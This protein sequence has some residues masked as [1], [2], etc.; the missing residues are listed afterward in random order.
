M[1]E[2]PTTVATSD[3]A[4][5]FPPPVM[6]GES[7]KRRI[8]RR[9]RPGEFR[10][11][12]R[13]RCGCGSEF[14]TLVSYVKSGHTKSCGCFVAVP[15]GLAAPPPVGDGGDAAVEY[16]YVPAFA[17]Y[18]VGDDGSAWSC[19]M[20]AGL[21]VGKG[22]RWVMGGTWHR[23]R[24]TPREGYPSVTLRRDNKSH[25]RCVHQLVML[26]FVGPCPDGMEVAHENGTR[27]DPRLAN[28]SYKTFRENQRDSYR[29]GTRTLG[30]KSPNAK[31]TTEVVLAIRAEFSTGR[32]TKL[33]LARKYGL[34]R[35]QTR[36]IITRKSWA[37]V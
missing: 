11:F 21:G 14:E 13:Y 31:A 27:L 8:H 32:F 29:H 34:S 5:G 7:F 33:D 36:D 28:L 9:T 22:S 37:H 6:I 16:R 17:G 24:A 1:S 25:S 10:R 35:T 15:V 19:W 26:A 18:R 2:R 30:E 4:S 3:A 20:Q 12:A 23:L